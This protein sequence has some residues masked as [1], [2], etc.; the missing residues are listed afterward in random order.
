LISGS[1]TAGMKVTKSRHRTHQSGI[2]LIAAS[3]SC[4]AGHGK[5]RQPD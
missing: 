3:V 5:M 2:A 1:L 4:A